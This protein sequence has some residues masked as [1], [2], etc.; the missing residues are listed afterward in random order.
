[1]TALRLGEVRGGVNKWKL[2]PHSSPG[3]SY[4][5]QFW[6]VPNAQGLRSLQCILA[7]GSRCS[8]VGRREGGERRGEEGE[9]VR[10]IISIVSPTWHTLDIS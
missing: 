4:P 1:M 8:T 7:H 5:G 6:R 9:E 2:E 3:C 10:G